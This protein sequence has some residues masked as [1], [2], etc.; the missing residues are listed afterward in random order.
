[1]VARNR[2]RYFAP[3][4]IAIVI[5]SAVLIIQGEL[6]TKHHARPRHNDISG[7][8]HRRNQK[9]ATFYVVKSGDSLSSISVR[10]GVSIPT[11]ESLNP[12]VDPNAI[13]TGQRLRLR[14]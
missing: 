6:G 11:L 10:T 13:R 4:A 5:A 8:V 3:I 9:A 12:G 14:Q 2:G 7:L 1:M